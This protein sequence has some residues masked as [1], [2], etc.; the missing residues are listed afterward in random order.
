M[1]K[2]SIPRFLDPACQPFP[3]PFFPAGRAPRPP[4]PVPPPLLPWAMARLIQFP[5]FSA[6]ASSIIDLTVRW[7]A[8]VRHY[9]QRSVNVL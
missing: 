4:R 6:E 5:R 1:D 7:S 3:G 9:T 8:S 2:R